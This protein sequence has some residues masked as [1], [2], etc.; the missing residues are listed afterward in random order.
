MTRILAL[1]VTIF[2]VASLADEPRMS[3][4]DKDPRFI[5][6]TEEA[7]GL[8]EGHRSTLIAEIKGDTPEARAF[9]DALWKEHLASFPKEQRVHYGPDSG[10]TQ[11]ELVRGTERVVV[12]S[13]HTIEKTSPKFF[14]SHSGLGIL[15]D[16]TRAEALAAE[17]EAY[18]LFRASFDA[19]LVAVTARKKL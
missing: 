16:R 18:R 12:G 5:R 8:V 9:V 6:I 14:A 19:I 15:G 17:P 2:M 7:I 3:K 4:V 10:F 1:L 13:W 11:I